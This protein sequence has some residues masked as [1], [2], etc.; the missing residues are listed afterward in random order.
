M[1]A[2]IASFVIIARVRERKITITKVVF[3]NVSDYNN[4]LSAEWTIT[5][6]AAESVSTC[7]ACYTM[8]TLKPHAARTG[9][10]HRT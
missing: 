7:I 4:S 2:I 6:F 1:S 10:T 9:H 8:A 5:E 3:R